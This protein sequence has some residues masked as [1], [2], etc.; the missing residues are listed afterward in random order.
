MQTDFYILCAQTVPENYTWDLGAPL[1][2]LPTTQAVFTT[3]SSASGYAPAL[4]VIFANNSISDSN[5][6]LI[7]YSWDFGDFYNDSNNFISLS[8]VSLVQ[9]TYVM[10]GRYSISLR[11]VQSRGREE[12]D[13]TGNSLICRGKYNLRWFW[14]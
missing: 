3:I 11:H 14:A 7:D 12:L 8:C 2:S 13:Q 5:F 9:H 6:N 4:N 10:P 1:V